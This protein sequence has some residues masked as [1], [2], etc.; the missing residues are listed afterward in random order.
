GGGHGSDRLSGLDAASTWTLGATD[1]YESGGQSLGFSAVEDMQ[2]GSGADAFTVNG[3]HTGDLLGGSGADTFALSASLTGSVSGEGGADTFEL[4][5]GGNVSMDIFGGSE[6]DTFR[7]DGGG[8]ARAVDGGAGGDTLD[9]S[10]LAGPLTIYMDRT[11]GCARAS[12]CV[13]LRTDSPLTPAAPMIEAILATYASIEFLQGSV[14]APD[15]GAYLAVLPASVGGELVINPVSSDPPVD[16]VTRIQLPDLQGFPGPVLIGGTQSPPLAFPGEMEPLPPPLAVRDAAGASAAASI[17]AARVTVESA[18]VVPG[19][20]VLMAG[21]I[22]LEADIAAGASGPDDL[23]SAAGSEQEAILVAVNDKV[24]SLGGTGDIEVINGERRIYAGSAALVTDRGIVNARQLVMELAG[25][26]LQFAVSPG[27]FVSSTLSL[28]SRARGINLS[29]SLQ[30][31]IT[32]LGLAA[33]GFL[34]TFNNPASNLTQTEEITSIDLA[35][36]EE[37][38]ALFSAIGQGL[39]LSL[40]QCEELEGCAP[41]VDEVQLDG[42]IEDLEA[43]VQELQDYLDTATATERAREKAEQL[44]EEYQEELEDF[45]N[46]RREFRALFAG[47]EEDGLDDDGLPEEDFSFGEDD[48]ETLPEEEPIPV[49]EESLP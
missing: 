6:G 36:L 7:F 45:L 9:M 24:G 5:A 1:S 10:L 18:I 20:L 23:E 49:R 28:L 16:G 12:G 37:E 40:S 15:A 3:A 2:G 19:T 47:G 39:A 32:D 48:E 26:D 38:L 27:A 46:Y 30:Q 35:L 42:I 8:V 17:D 14:A 4:N 25:G 33:V 34:V 22:V 21:D 31:Y 11:G 13:L 29:S 44:L 41:D 43:R